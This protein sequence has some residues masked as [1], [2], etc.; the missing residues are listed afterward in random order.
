MSKGKLLQLLRPSPTGHMEV[1]LSHECFALIRSV[2]AFRLTGMKTD[3]LA[4]GSDSGRIVILEYR[5]T[6]NAFIKVHEETFGRSGL[7]RIVPG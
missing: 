6:K 3:Y 4:V 2:A 7:R 1:I 5:A